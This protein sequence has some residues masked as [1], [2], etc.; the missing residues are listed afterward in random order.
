MFHGYTILVVVP[1]RGGSK[2]IKLKNIHP[3]CGKPLLAYTGELLRQLDFVDRAV[4]STDHVEIAKVA[5]SCGL[6]IPFYRPVE[7]S[8][9]RI[10][11]WEVLL[12]ALCEMERQDA[13][14]YDIVLML[15]P[16]SPLRTPEQITKTL[17]TLIEGQSEAVWTVSQTDSKAHP[18]KQLVVT[19]GKLTYYDPAGANIIARQQ[20]TPVYHRNGIAYAIR[21]SCLI[22]KHSIQGAQTGAVI[23]SEPVINI[24]TEWDI[25]W[26]EFLLSHLA[27]EQRNASRRERT[28]GE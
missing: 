27:G 19:D 24:D 14:Q 16:T 3:L 10:A 23:I 9:D 21:R 20:L 5:Q 7:L 26:A 13:R 12:H 18:L 8:G 1:A 4:V 25:L 28:T 15:Q 6:A 2:G 22:E 17:S 11:D